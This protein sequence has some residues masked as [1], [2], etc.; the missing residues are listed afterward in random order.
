MEKAEKTPAF[1]KAQKNLC[2]SFTSV[3]TAL[4]SLSL[5]TARE[6]LPNGIDSNIFKDGA[7]RPDLFVYGSA[8]N[9][10]LRAG[11]TLDYM[12]GYSVLK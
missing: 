10:G 9:R 12:R 5:S 1:R 8:P 6:Q 4:M 3:A 7:N 2:Y 11:K